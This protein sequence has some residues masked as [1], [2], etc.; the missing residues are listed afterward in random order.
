MEHVTLGKFSEQGL[1]RLLLEAPALPDFS[2]RIDFLSMQFLGVP[3]KESTLIGDAD[4]AEVFVIDLS[5]VDCFTFIDYVAALSVSGSFPG[6]KE[7][8]VKIRYQ[9]GEIAFE[10]RNHFFT[11]WKE[12]NSE[13]INDITEVIGGAKSKRIVKTLNERDDM[14]RI[15]PGVPSREREI[16]Y[17]PA[18]AV[19]D[20]VVT[21]LR[22]G[23][24]IGIYTEMKGLDV[25]HVGIFVRNNS[26]V[27]LRHASSRLG[28]VVDENFHQYMSDRPGIIVLRP[29]AQSGKR[30]E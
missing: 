2:S 30:P 12:F 17:I 24:Y 7:N 29:K 14:S 23:D 10:T 19:D 6:F 5:G 25:S 20:D 1:D 13:L 18:H 15:L 22:T 9:R 28:K 26:G 8:L 11:D 3:Y 21:G 4:T 27:F 16:V